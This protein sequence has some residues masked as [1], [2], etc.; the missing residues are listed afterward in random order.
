M[1][2]RVFDNSPAFLAVAEPF[3]AAR[4]VETNL[5]WGIAQSLPSLSAGANSPR[6]FLGAITDGERV[7]AVA[8][9]TPPRG[10]LLS[11]APPEAI[12]LLVAHF[13][14]TGVFLPGVLSETATAE[15]FAARWCEEGPWQSRLETRHRLYCLREV[16]FAG[17]APGACRP[18]HPAEADLCCDWYAAFER[19]AMPRDPHRT[20][21]EI[22]ELKI[23]EGSLWFWVDGEP[24]ALVGHGRGTP[25]G[26][27]VG[28][29]YTPPARRRRGYATAGVA[30]VTQRLLDSGKSWVC[31]YTN[32]ANPTSNSIYRRIGYEPVEDQNSYTFSD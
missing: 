31:L 11:Q 30:V 10:L 17:A 2:L 3:L 4:E 7:V 26:A 12:D 21:R 15:R 24:V 28:P 22:I 1:E 8:L 9:R 27:S 20:T 16:K 29:V 18:V 6:P 32:L 14:Q 25:A 23:S 19:E 13:R 5:I